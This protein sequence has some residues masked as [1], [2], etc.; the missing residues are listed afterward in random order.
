MSLQLCPLLTALMTLTLILVSQQHQKD[1]T[2][3][4]IFML[5]M[6]M[7]MFISVHHVMLLVIF[8]ILFWIIINKP[9]LA[10]LT[11]LYDRGQIWQSCMHWKRLN[12]M[13]CFLRFSGVQ[14]LFECCFQMVL[15]EQHCIQI[16]VGNA[17]WNTFKE[18]HFVLYCFCSLV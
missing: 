15:Y 4:C 1:E 8:S 14:I 3:N 16:Q 5:Y 17:M 9:Y 7:S 10:L 18:Q 2:Q 6:L 12:G 11:S 13:L